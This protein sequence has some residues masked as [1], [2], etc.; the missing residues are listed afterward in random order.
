MKQKKSGEQLRIE[1]EIRVAQLWIRRSISCQQRL[2]NWSGKPYGEFL[3]TL[4]AEYAQDNDNI[5]LKHYSLGR[6]HFTLCGETKIELTTHIPATNGGI[7]LLW[8]YI[9]GMTTQCQQLLE[10]LEWELSKHTDGESDDTEDKPT[11]PDLEQ[12]SAHK[13]ADDPKMRGGDAQDEL[14][15]GGGK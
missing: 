9:K 3:N 2:V 1:S 6:Q 15:V 4:S 11:S 5:A 10:E 14:P 7:L 8:S 13:T 12:P